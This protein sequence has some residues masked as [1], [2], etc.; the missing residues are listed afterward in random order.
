MPV[1]KTR[2]RSKPTKVSQDQRQNKKTD[3]RSRSAKDNA[4]HFNTSTLVAVFILACVVGILNRYHTAGMFENDR[5]FS[6]LSDL[7][8]EMTFRTEMGLYYSYFKT[9]INA[10]TFRQGIHEIVNDN[11]TEYG[12]T[13]N[14]LKRFNLYPELVLATMY[15]SYMRLA[16]MFNFE[17]QQCWKTERGQNLEPILSCEGMGNPFYFYVN[18]VF[19]LSGFSAFILFLYGVLLSDSVIGG[20]I[21]TAAFFFNHGEA[22][23]VQWTP[24][25]RESFGYP[26]CLLL[27][28]LISCMLKYKNYG[29]FWT[30]SIAITTICFMA[31]WQFASFALSTQVGCIFII[32]AFG[33]TTVET[34]ASIL[35]G[36]LLGLLGAYILLFG[37]EMILT[38]LFLSSLCTLQLI[39]SC[40][41]IIKQLKYRFLI[42]PVQILMFGFG[43]LGLKIVIGTVLNVKDDAHV[44]DILKSKFTNYSDFHTRLYTCAAEFDFMLPETPWKLTKTLVLPAACLALILAFVHFIQIES[45]KTSNTNTCKVSGEIFY[46]ALQLIVFTII[47]ILIMRLKLFFTPHLCIFSALLASK[48][49]IGDW[50]G[51][52]ISLASHNALCI[53]LIAGMA[54]Q[55]W[56]NIKEQLA[57]M[58]E[59]SNPNQERLFQWIL[60]ETKPDAVFAGPMPTMANVKLSTGRAI[61]NHPHYEDVGIRERTIKVYSMFSRRNHSQ[62]HETLKSLGVQFY[63]FEAG[64]CQKSPRPGCSMPDLFD[65]IDEENRHLK[66]LCQKIQAGEFGPFKLVYENAYY[67]VLK[68]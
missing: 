15:K 60:A 52:K 37:N 55:G 67:K 9:L 68:V 44:F 26:F 63:I 49:L 6:Y 62:V 32:Y 5:H 45:G 64:W 4:F 1:Q 34:L 36:L 30:F 31:S 38:S 65:L 14:T 27:M 59:Y 25:L 7:E 13:I 21:A 61:V 8:R 41:P 28:F 12:H 17:T 39:L 51:S 40:E 10:A 18:H 19:L 3:N 47:A 42:L 24:P 48:K 56:Q 58:G 29:G 53:L 22:T 50:L 20:I 57:I 43:T 11:V 2:P 23:R 16:E 35:R 66:P 46:N 54:V 33:Y